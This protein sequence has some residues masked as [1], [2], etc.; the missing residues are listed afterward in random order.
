M[1]PLRIVLVNTTVPRS[2]KQL[3]AGVRA[4]LAA[5]PAIVQPLLDS[6]DAVSARAEHLFADMHTGHV[7]TDEAYDKLEVGL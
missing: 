4:Q 2:T 5:E 3:V 1:P 6:I 7:A